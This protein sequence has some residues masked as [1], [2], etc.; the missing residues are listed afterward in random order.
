[1]SGNQNLHGGSASGPLRTTLDVD[2]LFVQQI[3]IRSA[4]NTPISTGYVLLA[5][6]KGGTVFGPAAI[7]ADY[8]ALSS[9]ISAGTAQFSSILSTN[10]SSELGR[11]GNSFT[12]L[13]GQVL[14]TFQTAQIVQDAITQN[15]Y[16]LSNLIINISTYST[17]VQTANYSFSTL[18]SYV[19]NLTVNYVTNAQSQN[20]NST[21]TGFFQST[22]NSF[23]NNY[24][25]LQ[26]QSFVTF[27]NYSTFQ[28]Q[29]YISSVKN[30]S[31]QYYLLLSTSKVNYS[32]L[33]T[34][35][36]NQQASYNQAL[37]TGMSSYIMEFSTILG[38][39]ANLLS[40]YQ[41]SLT[42]TV[43]SLSTLFYSI[44]TYSLSSGVGTLSNV[45]NA[46]AANNVNS[47]SGQ[48]STIQNTA[49]QSYQSTLST[50]AGIGNTLKSL[51]TS[52]QFTYSTLTIE[53]SITQ[54][55]GINAQ[56]YAQ[57]YQLGLTQSSVLA[58]NTSSINY[59][60]SVIGS[61][62]CNANSTFSTITNN[63]YSTLLGYGFSS[64]NLANN[65][66]NLSTNYL[67]ISTLSNTNS[68]IIGSSNLQSTFLGE[69]LSTSFG[70]SLS[71]I[72][73]SLLNVNY[74]QQETL[75]TLNG[76][77]STFSTNV[78]WYI[79]TISNSISTLAVNLT[80]A[81]SN[82]TIDPV[83]NQINRDLQ[84]I[85]QNLANAGNQQVNPAIANL[86]NSLLGII[87]TTFS[88]ISSFTNTFAGL[89]SGNVFTNNNTFQG[90]VIANQGI[91]TQ[92]FKISNVISSYTYLYTGDTQTYKP[93]PYANQILIQLWGA[94][95]AA[96]KNTNG[97]GG[98]YV[99]GLYS[100]DPNQIYNINVGGGGVI[101]TIAYASFNGGGKPIPGFTGG[102]GG[103]TNIYIN[104]NEFN[105]A[106]NIAVAGGGGGGGFVST[107]TDWKAFD[108]STSAGI[109]YNLN[110]S[111]A[112][113]RFIGVSTFSSYQTITGLT[114]NYLFSSLSS[115]NIFNLS[116]LSVNVFN[117][118][119][120][121]FNVFNYSTLS[122]NFSTLVSTGG[123][124]YST[125]S[126]NLSTFSTNVFNLSTLSTFSYNYSTLS[127]LIS[128]PYQVLSFSTIS[129][130]FYNFSSLS[131]NFST[132]VSTGGSRYSTLKY[133]LSTFSTVVFNP[134]LSTLRYIT[135][136]SF[137][138]SGTAFLNS[139]FLPYL[140]S[141]IYLTCG[142]WGG[143][144][145][146]FAGNTGISPY[147]TIS[148][149][150]FTLTGL[151]G[152]QAP[153]DDPPVISNVIFRTTSTPPIFSTI[154]RQSTFTR[155]IGD[156]IPE[157]MGFSP[158]Y[159]ENLSTNLITYS[160]N[161]SNYTQISTNVTQDALFSNYYSTVQNGLPNNSSTLAFYYTV[162]DLYSLQNTF[163]P[164]SLPIRGLQ[165]KTDYTTDKTPTA[166]Y[167]ADLQFTMS[168]LNSPF[169]L[170][171]HLM[172]FPFDKP[173]PFLFSSAINYI[174]S[175]L[176]TIQYTSSITNVTGLRY[177]NKT[178]ALTSSYNGTYL[179]NGIYGNRLDRYTYQYMSTLVKYNYSLYAPS[180]ITLGDMS[181]STTAWQLSSMTD[182]KNYIIN[183]S[184]IVSS[185]YQEIYV[186]YPYA[187]APPTFAPYIT[188]AFF[189][190]VAQS[191]LTNLV[192]QGQL[193]L[194]Y[195][196]FGD[197][198]TN[199]FETNTNIKSQR[200]LYN[201]FISSA[202]A[203]GLTLFNSLPVNFSSITREPALF[204][205][206]TSYVTYNMASYASNYFSQMDTGN[207]N[208]IINDVNFNINTIADFPTVKLY[209]QTVSTIRYTAFVSTQITTVSN[210]VYYGDMGTILKGANAVST[211]LNTIDGSYYNGFG[212][213]GGGG[214]YYGG[215]AGAFTAGSAINPQGKYFIGGGG[216][217][218]GSSYIS[219][220]NTIG[221]S[222]PGQT[223]YSGF[224]AHPTAQIYNSG[225]G[226]IDS[227]S[228]NNYLL[229]STYGYS[230]IPASARNGGNG[231]AIIT[232]YIDPFRVTINNG[233]QNFTP[234][235][236]DSIT[237]EFVV[238]KLVISSAQVATMGPSNPSSIFLDF[239]NYQQFY[240]TLG[241][242]IVSSFHLI[243]MSTIS[244]P[245][246]NFQTGSIYLN[247]STV[248]TNAYLDFSSFHVEN[249]W[250]G[251]SPGLLST[252]TLGN[253]FLFEYSI[254]NSNVYLTTP[255]AW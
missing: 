254:F 200:Q 100:V 85:A 149:S 247:I 11:I 13:Q 173:D 218:G 74:G 176:S 29:L 27:T 35:L 201:I 106:N 18:S 158:F 81:V 8:F 118:S 21:L 86:S 209:I 130:I 16:N 126:Y 33:S 44:A 231:L 252:Y 189:P 10:Y 245:T 101:S 214:G 186:N 224:F 203:N 152:T 56:L 197:A 210:I 102:G 221:N 24:S 238:N 141:T 20:S 4:N 140:N 253:T 215:E 110:N 90:P 78:F 230:N 193:I 142:S 122:T 135:T 227:N 2:R 48:L 17:F 157:L 94:G 53:L 175:T 194:N 19:H 116:T 240:L 7:Q 185:I 54:T 198:F 60:S 235:R 66:V 251:N 211:V 154:I 121:S 255:R 115:F 212:G 67:L 23:S 132:L 246:M 169:G 34:T 62:Y 6:G 241:D 127:T 220:L 153:V 229:N 40:T 187:D 1:M 84:Q 38:N 49:I 112:S 124:R 46:V 234:L 166:I 237:N 125:L 199:Y 206:V 139:T 222:V 136:S 109:I 3:Y 71:S 47:L 79:S 14:S 161:P 168:Q 58:N 42:G 236:I 147:S 117:F 65:Q 146:L 5:D 192:T 80:E 213:G 45:V 249:S 31:T 73:S 75:S 181:L 183:T 163:A 92:Y 204:S 232:E 103:A 83:S 57:F 76:N 170:A 98:A 64:I 143:A 89:S 177:F 72:T 162:R 97:G 113:N 188:D 82:W 155:Y 208:F 77:I 148:S 120:L 164:N 172:P 15:V 239:A 244:S 233:V 37:S 95:G 108:I 55:R 137:I 88:S 12:N 160:N 250:Q 167:S 165:T 151:G 243:P 134:T 144:G 36:A 195:S 184:T 217:G 131:T 219:L 50:T 104:E 99:E 114:I 180:T 223:F 69:T 196:V 59:L 226:G 26:G 107:F 30:I 39:E 111:F 174:S 87:S 52:L 156:F 207:Q 128:S 105:A 22:T 178:G 91:F 190:V 63:N 138:S 202:G 9:M 171:V 133:N 123:T 145:G 70:V 41:Y 191:T 32:T 150:D 225:N 248:S 93:N 51:S 182:T 216:G 242:H 96:G 25:S 129:S 159:Y 179:T 43:S 28:S 68:S 228:F 205:T 61:N 119:T